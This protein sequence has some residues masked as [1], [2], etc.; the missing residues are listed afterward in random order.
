MPKFALMSDLHRE[1]SLFSVPPELKSADVIVLAGDID[2]GLKGAEWAA[3]LGKPVIYVPGNH[4]Y[5]G[6]DIVELDKQF[7]EF[8]KLNPNVHVLQQRMAIVAGIRF[9]GCTL[10]TDLEFFGFMYKDW[11]ISS[12]KQAMPEYAKVLCNGVPLTPN[13]TLERHY[14]HRNW[15]KAMLDMPFDGP[16]VVV[17]HH[18]PHKN[19]ILP[20]YMKDGLTAAF[21]SNLDSILGRPITWCHGHTHQ[22]VDYWVG[23]TRI[24]SHPRGYFQVADSK[25]DFWDNSP[26]FEASNGGIR[27]SRRKKAT[28]GY[29]NKR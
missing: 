22:R 29:Y 4:E 17:T 1:V 3:T 12:V 20:S 13:D 24:L 23:D 16:T 19:S 25:P 5:D 2:T 10:W 28:A 14:H 11:C 9:L 8:Q 7:E 6:H 21:A 26:L 15:L 18:A 27:V